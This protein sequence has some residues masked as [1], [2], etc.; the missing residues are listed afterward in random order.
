MRC[1]GC[2][3]P[4][5]QMGRYT[6]TELCLAC[7]LVATGSPIQGV[8]GEPGKVYMVAPPRES[9]VCE[10]CGYNFFRQGKCPCRNP[11]N[12]SDADR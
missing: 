11:V 3:K 8:V 2:K 7:W 9:N 10:H 4:F 12:R 5:S 1:D 6:N